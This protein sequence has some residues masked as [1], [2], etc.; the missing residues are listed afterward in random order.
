MIKDV[1]NLPE[2]QDK[3][4]ENLQTE[5]KTVVEAI[6]E[7]NKNPVLKNVTLNGYT[8]EIRG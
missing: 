7:I 5:S 4:D 6:N 3:E 8:I 2:K 1:I